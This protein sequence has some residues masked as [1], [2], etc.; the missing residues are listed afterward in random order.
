MTTQK[1]T[2]DAFEFLNPLDG[3][4]YALPPFDADKFADEVAAHPDY[5]PQVT[6]S[7]ALLADDP[8]QGM[9]SLNEPMRALNVL[10]KRSI[11]KTLRNHLEDD[12]PA[13]GALKSL[14][15][16]L[17]F[18]VLAKVF[19]EWRSRSEGVEADPLGE[20]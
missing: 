9:D 11:V 1:K 7:D 2:A 13:W 6:L 18:D 14:I 16:G 19:T 8:Q 12:D 5:I 17:E 4:T 10:M 15:D 20:G 3:K